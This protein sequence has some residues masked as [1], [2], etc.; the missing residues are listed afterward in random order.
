MVSFGWQE[1]SRNTPSDAKQEDE[2]VKRMIDV[3]FKNSKVDELNEVERKT[4]VDNLQQYF[5]PIY[6]QG[7]MYSCTANAAAFA[8]EF[9]SLIRRGLTY[10]EA[11]ANKQYRPVSR[12]FIYYNARRLMNQWMF[13][14]GA[15]VRATLGALKMFGAPYENFW[16]YDRGYWERP[17]AFIYAFADVNKI[18]SYVLHEDENR[19]KIIDDVKKF[20][21][22][23]VPSICGF[24]VFGSYDDNF[25]RQ[26]SGQLNV[27]ETVGA[28]PFP[29][30]D[31]KRPERSEK[32]IDRHVVAIVGYDDRIE[33]ENPHFPG[34]K[35]TGAFRIRNSWG[36]S[37]GDA[38]YGWLPYEYARKDLAYNFWSLL[39]MKFIN[40][41]NF[42]IKLDHITVPGPY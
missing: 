39:W 28:F 10:R 1:E 14:D 33:I 23:G 40:T 32:D 30:I 18:D 25:E 2:R 42:D 12:L 37:W 20:L 34:V 31:E 5:P 26:P 21:A 24:K 6:D 8:V 4:R 27:E 16:P 13:E 15:S 9:Y 41:D 11:E 35:T 29:Y 38:G 22:A 17:D 36:T 3:L 19:E 7:N